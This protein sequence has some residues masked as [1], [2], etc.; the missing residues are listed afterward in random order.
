M[1]TICAGGCGKHGEHRCSG[2]KKAHYCGA[3]C[4][5][6]DRKT[7]K[8]TCLPPLPR[9]PTTH[10]TGCQ[11]RFS[12][13]NDREQQEAYLICPDCGYAPCSRCACHNRRGTCYCQDSNL[14]Y[15]YCDSVPEWYH[16]S[17]RTGCPYTGD[18][19]PSR[20]EAKMHQVPES[21]WETEPR[22]CGNC[23]E[24]KLCLNPAF[25]CQSWM[26]R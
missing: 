24:V 10:C 7:H 17:Q 25:R 21:A 18:S 19:H 16:F 23:G 2:C 26:C 13:S 1:D 15:K 4:Q 12:P 22:Q 3:E 11:V 14:G 5:K 8:K 6:K 20:G 9:P